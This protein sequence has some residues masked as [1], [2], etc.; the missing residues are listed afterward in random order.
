M[1]Q[2]H[3]HWRNILFSGAHT[4]CYSS[5]A[6]LTPDQQGKV[7]FVMHRQGAQKVQEL[8]P[9]IHLCKFNLK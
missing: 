7:C 9:S 6:K 3:L 4:P 8:H 5:K 2:A 1:Q